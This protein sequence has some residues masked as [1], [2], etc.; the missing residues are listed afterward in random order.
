MN[1]RYFFLQLLLMT[2][3]MMACSDDEGSESVTPTIEAPATYNFQRDGQS[4]VS[5]SGQTAR[6]QMS[7]ELVSAMMNFDEATETVL[8]TMY[9]NEADGGG[10]ANPFTEAALNESDKSVRQKVAA[11]YDYFFDNTSE[12]TA[13][14]N[15][16]EDWLRGQVNEVFPNEEELAAPGTAGQIADG[17]ATR[18]VNAAGLEY[19]QLVNKGLIGALMVDQML[20]NYLSAAVL[21]EADN[22]EENSAGTLAEDENYTTM[23]H[24]WDE[25]YGYAYGTAAEAAN[26]NTT[27]GEDD[28]FLNKYIGRVENDSDFAG[29]AD[30]IY[31]AFKLGRAAIVAGNYE[32]RDQQAAIIREKI[33][34]IVGIRAVYYLEQA[35]SLLAQENPDYGTVFHDLSEAYGFIYSLQFTRQPNTEAP[36]FTGAEVD[37]FLEDLLGD[38]EDGLWDVTP[39][40]LNELSE[41]IVAR[42]DFTMEQAG[43]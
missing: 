18:Y 32:V 23:E 34:E 7:D 31:D 39:E 27:I 20:N 9:R 13:I 33:S 2:V 14:K 5:F 3:W 43:S 42:F 16:F 28:N 35:E 10:D 1:N 4:T 30:E 25:A 6:I 40:T 11:S 21:D 38:G 36:Y 8:I 19:N 22:R 24:Q 37:G 29:I 41:T 17:D 15:Q 12:G 26:P